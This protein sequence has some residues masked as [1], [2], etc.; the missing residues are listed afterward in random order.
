MAATNSKPKTYC[1]C[2][3]LMG[4]HRHGFKLNRLMKQQGYAL[5]PIKEAEII[6]AHS[7]GTWLIPEDA[8]PKLVVYVGMP[9]NKQIP[10]QTLKDA[11]LLMVKNSPFWSNFNREIKSLYYGLTQPRRNW[12]IVKM[13]KTAKPVILPGVP[14]IFVIN[15]EDPWPRS[16]AKLKSLMQAMPWAFIELPGAHDDIGLHSE[17]YVEIIDHYARLLAQAD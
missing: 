5:K 12:H 7:A 6:I 14:A 10:K 13:A 4:G 9:L 11:K 3:G 2:Y 16:D 15:K 8:N 17:R 1:I